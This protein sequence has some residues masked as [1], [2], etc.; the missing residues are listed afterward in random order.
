MDL[1]NENNLKGNNFIEEEIK[2]GC[3]I[4]H[5]KE[6]NYIVKQQDPQSAGK[7]NWIFIKKKW[8]FI[9]W[10]QEDEFERKGI[11]FHANEGM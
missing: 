5:I 7:L 8:I 3:S 9:K 6:G 2:F 4:G 11:N 10:I 1:A